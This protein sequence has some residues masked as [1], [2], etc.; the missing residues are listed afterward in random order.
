MVDIWGT[1]VNYAEADPFSCKTGIASVAQVQSDQP[2]MNMLYPVNAKDILIAMAQAGETIY[3]Y[4]LERLSAEEKQAVL[5]ELTS[6]AKSLTRPG[7][8]KLSTTSLGSIT[9]AVHGTRADV[10]SRI[11]FGLYGGAGDAVLDAR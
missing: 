1:P 7:P 2:I 3:E 11:T 9:Y 8:G 6:M 4:Q 10:P 5:G